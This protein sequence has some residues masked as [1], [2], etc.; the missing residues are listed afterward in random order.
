VI[1]YP[2]SFD[3]QDNYFWDR[4]RVGEAVGRRSG[5]KS[6]GAQKNLYF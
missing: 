3:G 5:R 1:L 4:V 2:R 6:P